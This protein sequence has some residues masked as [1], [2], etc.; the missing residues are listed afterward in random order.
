M[1]DLE[2]NKAVY[3]AACD[4]V[5][6]RALCKNIAQILDSGA[7]CQVISQSDRQ[8]LISLG[9]DEAE[10]LHVL[11]QKSF[12]AAAKL[13]KS[14]LPLIAAQAR[15]LEGS[16][17]F[18]A[19]TIEQ[20]TAEQGVQPIHDLSVLG[21]LSDEEGEQLIEAIHSMRKT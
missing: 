4:A 15:A 3:G 21:Y 13:P 11:N 18:V 6:N 16:D 1:E 19:K 17:F 2:Q 7:E 8:F 20:L 5:V 14:N 10:A 12:D 9:Q